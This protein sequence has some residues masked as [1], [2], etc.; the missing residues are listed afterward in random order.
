LPSF[1]PKALPLESPPNPE[2][3][4]VPNPKPV[5]GLS[6]DRAPNPLTAVVDVALG[7]F[8]AA[9]APKPDVVVW[10]LPLNML[11]LLAPRL[12]N[13]DVLAFARDAKPELANA[14][15]DCFG[16]SWSLLPEVDLCEVF[17]SL[18]VDVVFAARFV[19]KSTFQGIVSACM[20]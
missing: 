16:L 11:G 18:S 17:S 4:P 20:A 5:A 1:E 2:V 12:P 14:D 7:G 3:A 8:A 9:N 15:V 19:A 10:A 6:P 13:G